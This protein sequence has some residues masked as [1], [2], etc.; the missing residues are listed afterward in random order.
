MKHLSDSWWA[1]ALLLV[2]SLLASGCERPPVQTVQTGYRGTGNEQ[3]Y[4]PRTLQAQAANNAVPAIAAPA[5]MRAGAPTA[6]SVYQNVN[7][8]RDLSLAEFGRTMDAMTQWVAPQEGCLYCHVEGNF[9]DDG[10]YTKVVARRMVQMVQKVNSEWKSHV[11]ETGVTCYTCHRGKPLPEQI[12]FRPAPE[13]GNGFLGQR[14]GQNTPARTVGMSSLPFDPFTPYL[15]DEASARPIRVAGDTTLHT[16][17]RKS[18]Q[19]AEFT[20]GLMMHFSQSL[21]VNCTY[22]HNSRA[23]ASWAES[24]PQRSTAWYGIRMARD[25]NGNFL[26]KLSA[27]FP[28]IPLGRLGPTKDAA[29]VNCATCHQGAY[30][31][32]YG[33]QAAVHYPALYPAP[34]PAAA[35]QPAEAQ[36]AAGASP[37][38]KR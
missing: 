20:Y 35:D 27:T 30:K 16:G 2:L 7:V 14:N 34:P 32:L 26:E 17:N 13:G 24:P 31:P 18:I 4:N 15:L 1:V 19:Q 3:V 12:W 21:G 5:R 29:K 8:L 11:A 23:F 36:V 22:C 33:A 38:G 9:A 6:G 10:K 37:A 28:E 25:I